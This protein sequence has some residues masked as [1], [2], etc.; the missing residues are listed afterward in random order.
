M[1]GKTLFL[2][3]TQ[4]T[5]SKDVVYYFSLKFMKAF[6]LLLYGNQDVNILSI[7]KSVCF[8]SASSFLCMH[9]H[10]S[11]NHHANVKLT[12]TQEENTFLVTNVL[13]TI[14]NMVIAAS[15]IIYKVISKFSNAS[16]LITNQCRDPCE[17]IFFFQNFYCYNWTRT[18]K[19]NTLIRIRKVEN[20]EQTNK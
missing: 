11:I 16:N 1:A 17:S 8:I 9:T 6:A 14:Q 15:Q 12:L 3:C 2:S 19:Y 13:V 18:L 5:L 20:T 4:H 10:I 7:W